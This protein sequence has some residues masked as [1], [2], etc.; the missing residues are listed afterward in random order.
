M[1][2]SFT[3]LPVVNLSLL[4]ATNVSAASPSGEVLSL[5]EQL[6]QVF[7]TSG[8]AYL[9]N[10]PLSFTHDEVFE[11]SKQFFSLPERD[12]MRLAKR[13]FVKR[14]ENTYRG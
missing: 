4:K 3:S 9:T 12:K 14:N 13:T 7:S 10:V 11:L 8:F 6:D 1:A 2:T 5:A